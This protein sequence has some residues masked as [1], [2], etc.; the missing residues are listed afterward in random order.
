MNIE[1]C[2]PSEADWYVEVVYDLPAGGACDYSYDYFKGEKPTRA[3][4]RQ[5]LVPAGNV[6]LECT[7]RKCPKS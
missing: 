7:I 6:L 5:Q 3:F 4:A 2:A 1:R